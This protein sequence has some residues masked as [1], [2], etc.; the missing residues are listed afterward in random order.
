VHFLVYCSNLQE[1]SNYGSSRYTPHC[2]THADIKDELPDKY[3]LRHS[4]LPIVFYH[5]SNYGLVHNTYFLNSPVFLIQTRLK[6]T[7]TFFIETHN[8]YT[9]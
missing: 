7:T 2:N 4:L 3:S 6:K 5:N 1:N 9:Y 8:L